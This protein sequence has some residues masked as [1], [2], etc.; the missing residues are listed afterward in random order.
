MGLI[1]NISNGKP[2]IFQRKLM[3]ISIK[4]KFD[5][6]QYLALIQTMYVSSISIECVQNYELFNIVINNL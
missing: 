6:T 3:Y 4:Y 2:T 1:H 5:Q